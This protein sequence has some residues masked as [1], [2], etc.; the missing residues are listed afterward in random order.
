MI[1]ALH[2]TALLFATTFS[3][4]VAKTDLQQKT[5]NTTN[6]SHLDDTTHNLI[7][8]DERR[9]EAIGNIV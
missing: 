8:V 6:F 7:G 4:D 1:A 5:P 3:A 2:I 9:L